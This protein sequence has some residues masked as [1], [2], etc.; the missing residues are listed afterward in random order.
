MNFI[1]PLFRPTPTPYG[2]SWA[3]PLCCPFGACS[4]L[5]AFGPLSCGPFHALRRVTGFA[6][7]DGCA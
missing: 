6:A 4:R 5:G 7:A 3:S 2:G 1:R